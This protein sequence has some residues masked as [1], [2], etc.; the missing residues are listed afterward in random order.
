MAQKSLENQIN[1]YI[2]KI[3]DIQNFKGQTFLALHQIES[4]KNP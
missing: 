2:I 3:L 4:R 1:N